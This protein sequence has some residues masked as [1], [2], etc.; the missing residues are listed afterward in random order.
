MSGL[1]ENAE[2][3]KRLDRDHAN[4]NLDSF[5]ICYSDYLYLIHGGNYIGMRI[6]TLYKDSF[7]PGIALIRIDN[8]I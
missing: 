1:G 3:A 6:F 5:D 4:A 7:S 2:Q 8:Y